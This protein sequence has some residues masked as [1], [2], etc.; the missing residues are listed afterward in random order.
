M[1]HFRRFFAIFGSL[2]SIYH[3]ISYSLV[4][5]MFCRSFY[6]SIRRKLMRNDMPHPVFIPR[7]TKST[8]LINFSLRETRFRVFSV[9][10]AIFIY[11]NYRDVVYQ[12]PLF[13]LQPLICDNHVLKL[14]GSCCTLCEKL[15]KMFQNISEAE[16]F[17]PGIDVTLFV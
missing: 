3:S 11:E 14:F 10:F 4:S 15:F 1:A 17:W 13:N 2:E 8:L 16:T 12:N 7:I 5:K 9:Y 6:R